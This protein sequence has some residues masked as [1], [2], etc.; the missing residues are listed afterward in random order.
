M[1]EHGLSNFTFELIEV[2]DKASLNKR[3]KRYIEIYSADTLGLNST[4]G[5]K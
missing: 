3:E 5:N 1:L 4:K 2:C